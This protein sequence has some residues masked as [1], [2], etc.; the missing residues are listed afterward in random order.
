MQ[1]FDL[2]SQVAPLALGA[3]VGVFAFAPLAWALRHVLAGE[4]RGS[5]VQGVLGL[6]VSCG[7]AGLTIVL[8][9]LVAPAEL[10]AVAAGET[11]GFL[12]C[13]IVAAA[14]VMARSES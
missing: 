4:N 11:A 14:V 9:H 12:V 8:V 13:L 5:M 1:G 6:M 2:A 10:I 3:V 7:V